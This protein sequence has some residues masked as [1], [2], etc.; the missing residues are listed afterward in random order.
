[1]VSATLVLVL[2]LLLLST[3]VSASSSALAWNPHQSGPFN[4][5]DSIS[6][7][8]TAPAGTEATSLVKAKRIIQ[9]LSS[10]PTCAHAATARLLKRCKLIKPEHETSESE[11]QKENAQAAYGILMALCETRQARVPIPPACR[12]FETILDRPMTDSTIEIVRAEEIQSCS[13]QLYHN[14]SWTSLMAFKAQSKDLCDSSRIDYQREELLEHFRQATDVIPD[15]IDALRGQQYESQLLMINVRDSAADV[16]ASHQEV[17]LLVQEQTQQ[18]KEQLQQM[19]TFIASHMQQLNESETSFKSA[20]A[21]AIRHASTDLAV[22]QDQAGTVKVN[23]AEIYIA[24]AEAVS[25]IS[26]D[27]QSS[28]ELMMQQTNSIAEQMINMATNGHLQVIQESVTQGRNAAIEFATIQTAQAEIAQAQLTISQEVL[29]TIDHT[30][31]RLNEIQKAVDMLPTS[32][33]DT[34]HHIRE[35]VI[36]VQTEAKY[37]ATFIVPS[38]LFLL[39][40][41]PRAAVVTLL[42]YGE[43]SPKNPRNQANFMAVLIRSIWSISRSVQFSPSDIYISTQDLQVIGL[44]LI[45]AA[46]AVTSLGYAINTFTTLLTRG[47]TR[48]RDAESPQILPISSNTTQRTQLTTFEKVAYLP[49]RSPKQ[50]LEQFSRSTTSTASSKDVADSVTDRFA[51]AKSV[52]VDLP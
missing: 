31:G 48:S 12:I 52:P 42:S 45:A 37:A 20:V 2:F 25:S 41:R 40:G 43:I 19:S 23:L 10:S 50:A 51:R 13:N 46:C 47:R 33:F 11:L 34:L 39:F 49:R 22:M 28:F 9:A 15:I 21:D 3:Q 44:C 26:A 1:M 35:K 4:H 5:V 14:P 7:L 32:W 30:H 16:L 36:R 38:I 6:D 18:S 29:H 17:S 27:V 24:A 8:L